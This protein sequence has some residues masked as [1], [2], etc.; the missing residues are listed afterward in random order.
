MFWGLASQAQ[1]ITCECGCLGGSQTIIDDPVNDACASTGYS[2]CQTACGTFGLSYSLQICQGCTF[3][4]CQPDMFGGSWQCIVTPTPSSGACV[5]NSDCNIGV[6]EQCI[7]GTC[8]VTTGGTAC[9]YNGDCNIG[10]GEL[11][12]NGVCQDVTGSGGATTN[13]YTDCI[14][15]GNTPS[16]CNGACGGSTGGGTAPP[17]GGGG[18]TTQPPTG[19]GGTGVGGP[20]GNATL[21]NFIGHTSISAL[22]AAIANFLIKYIAM[23]LAIL[24]IIYS[25][26]LFVTAGG[27]EE[28]IKK[29]KKN[30]SWTLLGVLIILS[31]NVLITYI[32]SLLGGTGGAQVQTFFNSLKP[33]LN[34]I[35][36]AGFALA[37][38]YFIWGIVMFMRATGSGDEQGIATGKKH[39]IWGIIGMAIMGAAPGIVNLIASIIP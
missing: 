37:T 17:T 31:A 8:Q 26:L 34:Q 18:T 21:P 23:P 12:I 3:S 27:N 38:V 24:M 25:G 5:Y 35:I 1:A 33:L 19:G 11:C 39:M 15:S 30:L 14:N 28:K 10:V 32:Q 20:M 13:C 4:E 7:S 36:L 29:A 2:M 9:Q 22:I 16:E 6:G